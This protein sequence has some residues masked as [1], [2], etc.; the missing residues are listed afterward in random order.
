MAVALQDLP[1]ARAYIDDKLIVSKTVEDHFHH[2]QVI[3]QQLDK[4]GL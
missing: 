3:F 4:F 2:L 1:F